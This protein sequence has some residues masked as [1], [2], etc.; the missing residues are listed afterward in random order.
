MPDRS[1]IR[2]YPRTQHIEGS[3]LQPGDEDLSSVPFAAIADS[4]LVVEEKM[5]GANCAIS[6]TSDGELLLQSRGH[7]LTGGGREKH[8]NL[9]KQWATIHQQRFWDLLGSRYIMYGEWLYAKH[10]VFYT[11]LPH[12][13]MEFDILDTDTDVYLDTPTRH[14]MLH[15]LPVVSVKRLQTGRVPSLDALTEL[16]AESEFIGPHHL[17]TLRDYCLDNQL[18]PDRALKETDPSPL[19]EGLY[20]KHEADG[21]VQGRYKWVRAGFLTAVRNAE[22][23][24][25]NRPVIP[26]QLRPGIDLFNLGDSE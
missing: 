19:M 5:D 9:F 10:T 13:F 25:L 7:Y 12:Y 23:H 2:K 24:W 11:Q 17:A 20:I 26:N 1:R 3:R 14:A 16:V 22:G 8:F 4:H 18:D 6:F 15:G 21:V